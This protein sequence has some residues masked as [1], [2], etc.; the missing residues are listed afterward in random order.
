VEGGEGVEAFD[1]A[2]VSDAGD[3]GTV[4]FRVFGVGLVY[5][6]R[7]ELLLGLPN[8]ASGFDAGDGGLECWASDPERSRHLAATLVL[9]NARAAGGTPGCHAERQKGL[10]AELE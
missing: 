8:A 6:L 10:P 3:P 2:G 1:A 7:A 9:Y 4:A 5:R